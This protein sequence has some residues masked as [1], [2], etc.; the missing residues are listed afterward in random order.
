MKPDAGPH[1]TGRNHCDGRHAVSRAEVKVRPVSRSDASHSAP[2]RREVL[3]L[4]HDQ[5]RADGAAPLAETRRAV[6]SAGLGFGRGRGEEDRQGTG[7]RR[8]G[9][10]IEH[11]P[12]QP[13]LQSTVLPGPVADD[14]G[15]G[16][17]RM[18]RDAAQCPAVLLRPP[19]ELPREDQHGELAL[20]VGDPRVVI[21]LALE[22][23]E[24]DPA[25]LMGEA[26]ERDDTGL[27]RRREQG[28]QQMRG[29]REMAEIVRA[30]LLLEPVAGDAPGRESHHARVV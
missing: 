8:L 9:Q 17:P 4:R 19:L 24:G 6:I 11:E 14:V 26:R 12:H 7:P 20:L 21:A 22:V 5:G 30:D 27:A 29:Q 23:V 15:H 3:R 28:R 18:R 2:R 1:G 10:R 25:A 16:P 13:R